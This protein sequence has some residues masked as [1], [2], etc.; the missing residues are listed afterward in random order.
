MS[1]RRQS[2]YRGTFTESARPPRA[3]RDLI[4]LGVLLFVASAVRVVL[5]LATKEVFGTEA[6][7]ALGCVVV[8]GAASGRAFCSA[9]AVTDEA[10]RR[11]H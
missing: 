7:L 10:R 9:K 11:G 5:A 8:L 1:T 4:A 6:T 3:E 2:P